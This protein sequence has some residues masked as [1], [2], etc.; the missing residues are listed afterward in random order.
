MDHGQTPLHLA[1]RTG[2][3]Q[4]VKYLIEQGAYVNPKDINGKDPLAAAKE[5][6]EKKGQSVRFSFYLFIYLLK[7]INENFNFNFNFLFFF[8]FFF[9][10][11]KET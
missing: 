5:S 11:G 10:E 6:L 7:L 9:V 8:F 4:I 3:F 2:N 1:A